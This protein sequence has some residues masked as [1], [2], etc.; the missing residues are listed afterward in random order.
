MHHC[1]Y[2]FIT[3]P[4][5]SHIYQISYNK[6]IYFRRELNQLLKAWEAMRLGKDAQIASLIERGKRMEEDVAEKTR[7]IDALRRKLFS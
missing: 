2:T 4:L 3:D 7:T 6:H 1:H 5:P